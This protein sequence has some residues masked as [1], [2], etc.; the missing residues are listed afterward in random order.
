MCLI[1]NNPGSIKTMRKAT[2]LALDDKVRKSA[3]IIGDQALLRRLS[4]GNMI[5]IDARYHLKCLATLYQKA[6]AI[7][8]TNSPDNSSTALL[9]A[10]A[11]ADLVEYIEAQC[12]SGTVFKMAEL[13]KLYSSRLISLGIDSNIH[14]TRLRQKLT[15]AVPILLRLKINQTILI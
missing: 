9:K 15:A 1:C 2:T 6:A 11:F 3:A 10:Q 12:G 4:I 7:E 8:Q 13:A 14:S 5:A